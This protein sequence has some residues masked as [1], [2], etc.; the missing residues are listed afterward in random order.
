MDKFL[1]NSP[2]RKQKNVP[3]NCV[4]VPYRVCRKKSNK[5]CEWVYG[6]IKKIKT[7]VRKRHCRTR[8][9]KSRSTY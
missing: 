1:E 8:R 9:N 7:G 3:S 4:T 5:K 6:S 2:M